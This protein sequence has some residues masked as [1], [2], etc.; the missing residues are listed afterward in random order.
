MCA[1]RQDSLTH[2]STCGTCRSRP[3]VRGARYLLYE[4]G[5]LGKSDPHPLTDAQ[6]NLN[7]TG[8]V[9][10]DVTGRIAGPK[11]VRPGAACKWTAETTGGPAPFTY[12]WSVNATKSGSALEFTYTNTSAPFTLTMRVTDAALGYSVATIDV[13]IDA[14]APAC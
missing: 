7:A 11:R 6:A 14:G 1:L 12:E 8:W 5:P 4:P 13:A 3:N 2:L 9:Y 10:A